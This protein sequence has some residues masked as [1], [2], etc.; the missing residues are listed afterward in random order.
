MRAKSLQLC[1]V[2]CNPMDCSLSGSPVH[3]ILQARRVEWVAKSYS[4]GYSLPRDQT[5]NSFVSHIG[6]QVLYYYCHLDS[7][8][9]SSV[10]QLYLTLCHPMDCSTPS[11]PVYHKLLELAQLMSIV[12]ETPS[13]HLIL[14]CPR[15]LPNLKCTTY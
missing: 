7:V 10:A 15:L 11:F 14:C 8:Q 4:R 12:S 13:N 3:G 9:F 6:R 1:P 2:L 5:C